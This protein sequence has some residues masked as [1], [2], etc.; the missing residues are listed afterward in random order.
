MGKSTYIKLQVTA[1][2]SI[3]MISS[4]SPFSLT[5]W[6][7]ASQPRGCLSGHAMNSLPKQ[8]L[9]MKSESDKGILRLLK[10]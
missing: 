4:L 5:P 6:S 2:L 7:Q 1:A 8:L 10:I 9:T 3:S